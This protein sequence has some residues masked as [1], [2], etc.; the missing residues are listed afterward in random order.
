MQKLVRL[1]VLSVI[2]VLNIDWRDFQTSPV[3]YAQSPVLRIGIPGQGNLSPTAS[4]QNWQVE[5][6]DGDILTFIVNRV[7]GDLDP[8]LTILNPTGEVF[9]END[10]RLAPLIYDAGLE[11][12][13]FSES[14]TYTL[15]VGRYAGSGD[16]QVWILPSYTRVWE[17]ED[18]SGEV[19]RW[20]DGRFATQ[21][22]DRLILATDPQFAIYVKPDGELP[23]GDYYLQAQF[24]WESSPDDIEATTGLMVRIQDDGTRRPP[25]Y[26][27][28]IQPDGTW[29]FL[30][31][32]LGE[33]ETLAENVATEVL[34]DE[35][36]TLG[37]W[38][39]NSRF[40]LYANGEVLGEIVDDTFA[41]GFWGLHIRG[42]A[43]S[44]QVAVDDLLLTVPSTPLPDFPETIETWSSNQPN[45]ILGELQAT[46]LI[47]DTGNR[48]YILT[49]ENYDVGAVQTRVF[50]ASLLDTNL[51]EFVIG[52]DVFIIEGDNIACGVTMRYQSDTNQ[53]F[54]Y[55][56]G[57]HGAGFSYVL[58][59]E[60]RR[61]T[62]D[63]IP[64]REDIAQRVE[65]RLLIVAQHDIIAFY[66]DGQLFSI[67]YA[68][69]VQGDI[70]GIL[71]NYS[72]TA[73][74]CGYENLWTYR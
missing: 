53:M 22:E 35:R 62:Y 12:V 32:N 17:D 46:N 10:D 52:V 25:G 50:P 14:G 28:L 70:G 66:V 2:I 67:E 27:F 63:Y 26:Y 72:T 37:I 9:K 16:Y 15:Q 19:S 24:D 51:T 48:T 69:P 64:A 20:D 74:A 23:L 30:K 56:D 44:A 13:E 49:A 7:S 38:T 36:I 58:N 33:F 68:P 59:G 54:A 42:E 61:N 45:D 57:D 31:R 55:V 47:T 34:N 39:L 21:R 1:L 8:T 60:F 3:S 29:S 5:I 43:D 6:E 4:T 18:F 41:E 73:A 40:I 71:M 11:S 65:H